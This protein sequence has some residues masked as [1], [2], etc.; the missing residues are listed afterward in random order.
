[1]SAAFMYAIA[2]MYLGAA[3]CF[4]WEEK[5]AYCLLS[6]CWGSGN[7]ILGYISK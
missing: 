1:M 6:I 5:T 4:A 3:V 2:L 7:L